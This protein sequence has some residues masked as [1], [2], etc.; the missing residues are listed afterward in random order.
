MELQLN[1]LGMAMK[2]ARDLMLSFKRKVLKLG[3]VLWTTFSEFCE[4]S[5]VNGVRYITERRLH[6]SER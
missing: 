3:E 6:W 2:P 4:S 5:S 1:N